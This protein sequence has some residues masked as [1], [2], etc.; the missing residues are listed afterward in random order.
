[1]IILIKLA[2]Q[3][4]PMDLYGNLFKPDFHPLDR[5]LAAAM[6]FVEFSAFLSIKDIS[7]KNFHITKFR[8]KQ[9]LF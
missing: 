6:L 3:L 4:H 5:F 9:G 2:E 1:M 7:I 8:W